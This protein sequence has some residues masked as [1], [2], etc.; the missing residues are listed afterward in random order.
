MVWEWSGAALS[1][2]INFIGIPSLFFK[3][4]KICRSEDVIKK[5]EEE[6][7]SIALVYFSGKYFNVP[8]I[9]KGLPP[10][11]LYNW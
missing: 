5:I 9:G 4:E 11:D 8:C 6:G 2:R 10:S 3:G 7:E 1:V